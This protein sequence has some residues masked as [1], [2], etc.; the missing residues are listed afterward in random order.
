MKTRLT[1]LLLACL[2]LCGCSASAGTTAPPKSRD[3]TASI[4]PQPVEQ[5]TDYDPSAVTAAIS[6]FSIQLLQQSDTGKNILLSPLSVLCALSMT[7]N[8]AKNETLAQME[9]VLGTPI[10]DLNQWFSDI[11]QEEELILANSIWL[12]K[13]TD[14]QVSEEFLHTNANY[15]HAAV[16]EAPFDSTTKD[17]INDF[18]LEHT[19]GMIEQILDNIPDSARMYLVNALA[20]DADWEAP[21]SFTYDHTFSCE[22]GTSATIPMMCSDEFAFLEDEYATGFLKYYKGGRYAFAA[23]LPN[24][25]MTL[26]EYLNTL[27]GAHLQELFLHPQDTAVTVE[28]PKFEAEFGEDLTEILQ[29]MGITDAF[30]S[31]ADFSGIGSGP[32]FL[33]ISQVLH[34]AKISVNETG[35]KAGAATAVEAK[36]SAML[37]TK[38]VTLERPFL[39]FLIDIET[40][41]PIFTGTFRT[42]E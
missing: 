39:Y 27:D 26:S 36:E 42:P 1:A 25:G 34:K 33:F 24:E 16:Y 30:S 15:Y 38:T 37:T 35:T 6:A 32:D 11:S 4:D 22:D 13:Q 41:L 3:L 12:K 21:Y 10:T 19:N 5:P 18:V 20:F 7:A 29:T 17:E 8:G 28:L 2:L 9:T 40:G 31:H 14:F 23:L